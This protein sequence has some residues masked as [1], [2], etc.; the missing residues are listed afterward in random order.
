[1]AALPQACHTRRVTSSYSFTAELWLY[2][3]EAGW[4]FLTLPPDVA[5]DIRARN[6]GHSKAFGS[7]QVT[8]EISGHTWQT[9]LFPDA[10][11]GTYLLPVKKAIR[12]RARISEGDAVKVSLSVIGT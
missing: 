1:M 3:G 6:A 7:I 12:A 10:H 2:P 5:D 11:Q 9:S 4:H 8:A